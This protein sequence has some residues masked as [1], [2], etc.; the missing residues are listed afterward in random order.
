NGATVTER[1]RVVIGADGLHSVLARA[2]SP[3]QYHEKPKL[4]CGYYAYWSGLPM[5]GRFETYDRGER[6]FAA[7]PTEDGL[8]V[9]VGGW[10]YR[11]F[12]TNRTDHERHYLDMFE[13]APAFAERLKGATRETRV[14]GTAVPNFFRKP[15]GS[16]W[17]LVGDS[18]YHKD[19]IT[20][21][22][23]HD[24]FRDAE[25]VATGLHETWTGGRG[26][27]A[28]MAEYQSSRDAAVLPIYEFTA[29]IAS[30]DPPSPEAA[31]LLQAVAGNQRAMDQ[32]AQVTGAV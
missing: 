32:F 7:W 15:Y 25:L 19:F 24:A 5:D 6:A 13:L 30:F 12:E 17:V 2:V 26:F 23:I 3:E 22:G 9:V 27:D 28:T 29:Q 8:T 10:P 18:G 11:E 14:V 20:A 4:L 21:Q 31:R 16:G 1:A